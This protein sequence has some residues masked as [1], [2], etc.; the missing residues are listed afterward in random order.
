MA[1][2]EQIEA[3]VKSHAAGVR[4]L[5]IAERATQLFGKEGARGVA[6][7]RGPDVLRLANALS[8][9]YQKGSEEKRL[10]DAMLLAVPR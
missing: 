6:A 7:R 5:P 9:L 10:V 3:L 1:T 2:A 8:A 4:L